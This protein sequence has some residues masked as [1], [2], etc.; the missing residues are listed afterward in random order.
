VERLLAR[1]ERRFGRYAPGNLTYVLVAAQLLGLLMAKAAPDKA[2]ALPF[3]RHLVLAGELWRLVSWLAIPPSTEWI[4]AL[5]GLYWLYTIGTSL[6]S[7]WGAFKFFIYWLFGVVGTVA[8][9]WIANVPA[10][11]TTFLM[12]LFLAFATQWPDYEIRVMLLVPMKVKWLAYLDGAYLVYFTFQQDGL[13]MLLPIVGVGNYLLFFGPTLIQHL[14]TFG[15]H[16]AR[17]GAR[18]QLRAVRAAVA[19]PKDRRCAICGASNQD[20]EVELRVC[21]CAKCGGV[22]R[23]LCLEHVR[24]H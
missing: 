22:V 24:N 6:E 20:P 3:D 14:R 18:N 9:A 13:A 19:L 17:A 4:W 16:A 15:R 23:D 1:L 7:E 10:T 11:N 8:T 21:D 2:E 5:F 12:T